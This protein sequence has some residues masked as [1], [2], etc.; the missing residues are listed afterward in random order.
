MFSVSEA[1]RNDRKAAVEIELQNLMADD[2]PINIPTDE[3]W[4]EKHEAKFQL[5]KRRRLERALTTAAQNG[6]SSAETQQEIG[7]DPAEVGNCIKQFQ[8]DQLSKIKKYQR[9]K[10]NAK[11]KQEKAMLPIEILI[12]DKKFY[13]AADAPRSVLEKHVA[14]HTA[15]EQADAFVVNDITSVDEIVLWNAFL[16][17]GLVISLQALSFLEGPAVK[18]KSALS[19]RRT[20]FMS[21]DFQA[22]SPQLATSISYRAKNEA[23]S[24]WKMVTELQGFMACFAKAQARQRADAELLAFLGEKEMKTMQNMVASL[25]TAGGRRLCCKFLTHKT[26]PSF[27]AKIDLVK[28]G[29]CGR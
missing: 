12:Q 26:A 20:V 5:Q 28:T 3:H 18:Y 14:M 29:V 23:Q 10:A 2:A 21:P 8:H 7:V 25:C 19:I 22:L 24:K 15:V 11:T 13:V 1:F 27:L 4:S 16:S 17:G 6:L 9:E